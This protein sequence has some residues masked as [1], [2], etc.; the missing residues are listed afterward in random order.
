M[1]LYFYNKGLFCEYKVEEQ[2]LE[3]SD[4]IPYKR[5]L[6]EISN[7]GVQFD[8]K[9]IGTDSFYYDGHEMKSFTVLGLRFVWS[10]TYEDKHYADWQREQWKPED[11]RDE[12]A[13]KGK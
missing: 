4:A 3:A 8:K 10:Y 5:R 11:K 13:I 9:F 7:V 6:R 12:F 1:K 2:T